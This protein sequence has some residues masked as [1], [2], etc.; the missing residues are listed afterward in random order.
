MGRI[1]NSAQLNSTQL[2]LC[3]LFFGLFFVPVFLNCML[4][5]SICHHY[6][7]KRLFSFLLFVYRNVFQMFFRAL[8]LS[9]LRLLQSFAEKE[10]K[11]CQRPNV[12]LFS[13]KLVS[14]ELLWFATLQ[15]PL[16]ETTQSSQQCFNPVQFNSDDVSSL[17]VSRLSSPSV[18]VFESRRCVHGDT[19][20][21]SPQPCCW[22]NTPPACFGAK[23]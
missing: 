3:Q 15:Q 2:Q 23:L 8:N 16:L 14:E 9:G 5:Y 21:L 1:K 20:L 22:S 11:R 18:C 12:H 7:Q 10:V 6:N 17:P 19:L 4:I 13:S